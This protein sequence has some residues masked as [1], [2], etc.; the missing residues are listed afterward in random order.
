MSHGFK[1]RQADTAAEAAEDWH[2]HR[3]A[4]GDRTP[5][6][7][8]PPGSKL[9]AQKPRWS[10]FP[11]DALEAVLSVLEHG[12]VKYSV[13]GWTKVP[14]SRRRYY[15]ALMRHLVA[16]WGGERLDRES[17]LP[18]LAHLSCNALFLLALELRAHKEADR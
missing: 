3:E 6:T 15:D 9:D 11:W 13:D 14:E 18:H 8:L 12:A 7:G 4:A 10:L 17:G 5:A 16:W 2:D 1:G